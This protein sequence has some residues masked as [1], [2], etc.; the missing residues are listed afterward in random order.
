MRAGCQALRNPGQT[1]PHFL[2]VASFH[3]GYALFGAQFTG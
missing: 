2:D 3:P 1:S